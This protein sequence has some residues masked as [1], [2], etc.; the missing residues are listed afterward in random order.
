VIP[1]NASVRSRAAENTIGLSS[2]RANKAAQRGNPRAK[3]TVWNAGRSRSL[4]DRGSRPVI[5][6]NL[7]LKPQSSCFV[8]VAAFVVRSY[9]MASR[10]DASALPRRAAGVTARGALTIEWRVSFSC[11][12]SS[13]GRQCNS[14]LFLQELFDFAE[15]VLNP[16]IHIAPQ[17]G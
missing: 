16:A 10:S 5:A 3:P 9:P 14:E 11:R 4:S 12:G 2:C 13:S 8:V 1:T 7:V 15:I 6:A 17:H